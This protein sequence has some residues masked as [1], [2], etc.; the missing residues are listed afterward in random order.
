MLHLRAQDES[1]ITGSTKSNFTIDFNDT[2]VI[3]YDVSTLTESAA[4]DGSI[5]TT[6]NIT[7][8]GDTF[9][10]V[11]V[12]N[13]STV[14]V[15]NVPPGLTAVVTTSSTTAGTLTLTGTATAHANANDIANLSVT[16]MAVWCIHQYCTRNE[17]HEL[18]EN[19]LCCRL[20]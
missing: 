4:L 2:P 10:S 8:T 13:G 18:F 7:L 5:G 17:R 16:L 11:G 14:I 9:S 12:Q 6:V 19:K 15:S 20:W 3:T 1:Y